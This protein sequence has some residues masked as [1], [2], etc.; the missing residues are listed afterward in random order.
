MYKIRKND[1]VIVLTGKDEGRHGKVL[2]VIHSSGKAL[3]EGINLVK[4]HVRPNPQTGVT[5][6]V[7]TRESFINISNLAIYNPNTK[8][9]DR[10]GI[11][12]LEDRRKVRIFKSNEELIDI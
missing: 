5:G 8:K 1:E 6:G 7:V 12:V 3:V 4:K 10:V 9:P 11:K 2:Q